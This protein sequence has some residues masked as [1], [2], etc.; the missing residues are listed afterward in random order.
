MAVDYRLVEIELAVPASVAAGY[1]AAEWGMLV[2]EK[3][4]AVGVGVGIEA[5]HI[6][7]PGRTG[8]L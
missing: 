7:V 4:I 5:V 8:Q 6:G 3:R 2:I 1:T